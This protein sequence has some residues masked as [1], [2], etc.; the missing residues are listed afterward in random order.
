MKIIIDT[1]IIFSSLLNP[2]ST[3]SDL[4]LNSTNTFEFYSPSIM[5]SELSKHKNKLLKISGLINDE[6]EELKIY[7]LKNVHLLPLETIS[8]ESWSKGLSLVKDIDEK[9]APFVATSID[10][11]GF[12]WTGDKKLKNGLSSNFN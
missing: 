5:L 2:K 6:L 4:I 11:N 7:L 10:L 12:L 1:N 9:D 8:D 3:I